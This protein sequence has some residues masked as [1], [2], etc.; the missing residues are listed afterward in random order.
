MCHR[1]VHMTCWLLRAQERPL[2]GGPA[3]LI[4]G[5]VISVRRGHCGVV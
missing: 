2:W 3:V 5:V 1:Y 4:A